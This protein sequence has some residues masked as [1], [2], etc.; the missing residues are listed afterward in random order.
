G[1]TT[2]LTSTV[3]IYSLGSIIGTSTSLDHAG[4]TTGGDSHT[5][6]NNSGFIFGIGA[7]VSDYSNFAST[8]NNGGTIQGVV[9]GIDIFTKQGDQTAITNS[10]V[11]QGGTFSVQ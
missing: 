1:V 2:G 3:A 6:L 5:Q 7:G 9:F 8:I 11:I 10:G 4:V